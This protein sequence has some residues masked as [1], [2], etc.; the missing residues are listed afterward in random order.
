M[1]VPDERVVETVASGAR[2]AARDK[3]RKCNKWLYEIQLLSARYISRF[4]VPDPRAFKYLDVG[5][6]GADKTRKFQQYLR[7]GAHAVHGADIRTWGP[8][9]ADKDKLGIQFSFIENGVLTHADNSVDL[10]T[11]IYTLH[12]VPDRDAFAREMR[13]VLKP[14]GVLL[15]IEHCVYTDYDCV[16]VNI[17]HMLFSAMNHEPNSISDPTYIDCQN[18]YEWDYTMLRAGLAPIEKAPA[19]FENE[20]KLTYENPFYGFYRK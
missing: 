9:D 14:G 5:C 20:Y 10:I 15:L 8:Y 18:M 7:L 2:P 11:C 13:R 3:F 1:D 4:G 6:G 12:H 19:S 17:Q 16:L